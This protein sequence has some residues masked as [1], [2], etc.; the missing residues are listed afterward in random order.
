MYMCHIIEP[1][2]RET[3]FSEKSRGFCVV[4]LMRILFNVSNYRGGG[5]KCF[6]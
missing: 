4:I 1:G 2:P 5:I 6:K 3:A